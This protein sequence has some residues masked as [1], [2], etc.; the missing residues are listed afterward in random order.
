MRRHPVV[1]P[2]GY[3]FDI[4]GSYDRGRGTLRQFQQRRQLIRLEVKQSGPMGSRNRE[5]MPNTPLFPGDE[6]S[7]LG[8]ALQHGVWA[9]PT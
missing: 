2:H 5:H 6:Q 4:E 3:T 8:Q 9:A 1:L 7:N